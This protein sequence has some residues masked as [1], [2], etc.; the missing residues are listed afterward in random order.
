MWEKSPVYLGIMLKG[1]RSD[2]TNQGPTLKWFREKVTMF[3]LQL[4]VSLSLFQILRKIKF[5]K[6]RLEREY[7]QEGRSKNGMQ[8]SYAM[9][10]I[11]KVQGLSAC[12]SLKK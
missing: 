3:L 8:R 7:E 11:N 2:S 12:H 10:L 5:L 1:I 4:S 9:F 6:G